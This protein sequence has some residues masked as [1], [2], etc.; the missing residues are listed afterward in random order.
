MMILQLWLILAGFLGC[1]L[2][3]APGDGSSYCLLE[4]MDG[5]PN[6]FLT[7]RPSYSKNVRP[8]MDSR[9]YMSLLLGESAVWQHADGD[10]N[11][12]QGMA[13]HVSTCKMHCDYANTI[14][15][16]ATVVSI[17]PDLFALHAL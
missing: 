17:E 8:L 9:N 10:S 7:V 13:T 12:M 5:F 1:S 3:Q 11:N 14:N 2:S 6:P 15:D 16:A 4:R